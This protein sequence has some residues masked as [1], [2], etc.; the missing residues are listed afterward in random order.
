MALEQQG[1]RDGSGVGALETLVH[2]LGPE[3]RANLT[4]LSGAVV[5]L[6][7]NTLRVAGLSRFAKLGDTVHSRGEGSD[8]LGEVVRIEPTSLVV[9][10]YASRPSAGIASRVWLHGPF[11]I[12]PCLAWRSRVI[13]ALGRPIDDGGALP[14]GDGSIPILRAPPAAL[15]RQRP[16]LPL[17]SG[18]RV[19][20]LFAP[21]CIGQRMGIF[22]GSGVG[23]S[24]LLGMLAQAG[25]FDSIVVALVG[26]RSREV[27]EFIETSL[28]SNRS[29]CVI[30]AATGDESP[31]LR[32]LAP[33]T[34]MTIAET[35][36]DHGQSVLL[37]ID[38]VTRY[39]HA[40]R[41]IAMAA[42]E[43]PVARGYT[44]SVFTDLPKLLE[45]AGPGIEGGGSITGL[46]TVLVD[47]DDHNDPVADAIRGTLD[48][49]I[50]LERAI[51]DSGRLPAVDPLKSLSRLAD[52]A[53]TVEQTALVTLLRKHIGR[54]EETRELRL[55][56]GYQA[57]LDSDVDKAV[58][59]VPRLYE[60]VSQR[61]SDPP[62]QD[63]FADLL[64]KLSQSP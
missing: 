20:D 5:E 38:S 37:V 44:P 58:T 55:L 41:E 28:G 4:R 19:I 26:E 40:C 49:H 11:E 62:S 56:G 36:R 6:T 27:R 34:A 53:L 42:G 25:S 43:P 30:V 33:L 18:V 29:R 63:V 2:G 1:P 21:L 59:I 35:F 39:A 13:D 60:F 14:P 54:F 50:V 57:G 32:R 52:R 23:K 22:A 7:P 45:R 51:A 12:N 9:K 24:T 46:F 16:S 31:M 15:L 10:P 48:G 3:A 8:P 17:R 61:P 64:E 47:G